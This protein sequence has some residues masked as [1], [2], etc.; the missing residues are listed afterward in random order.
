GMSQPAV[1]HH[2]GILKSTNLISGRRQGK[3]I[4]YS[5]NGKAF[6][7][8]H[9]EFKRLALLAVEERILRGIPVSPVLEDDQESYCRMKEKSLTK[10]G[11]S[12]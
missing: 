12:A 8:N 7:D 6:I 2:L 4:Y 10:I 11:T 3:W 9:N 5:I 1:S